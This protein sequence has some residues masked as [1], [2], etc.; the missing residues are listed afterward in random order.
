MEST[1]ISTV[2]SLPIH[3]HGMS[4]H[5]FRLS[6]ISCNNVVEFSVYKSCTSIVEFIPQYFLMLF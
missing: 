2:L 1:N 3:E 4:F 6:L 5:L